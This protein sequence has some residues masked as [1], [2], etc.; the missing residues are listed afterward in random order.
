[1]LVYCL[2]VY[3]W[4]VKLLKEIGKWLRYFILCGNINNRKLVTIACHKV[5]SPTV[6][7]AWEDLLREPGRIYYSPWS[8]I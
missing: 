7:G 3:Y 1:M 6:E 2:I 5:Y 8:W 4:L